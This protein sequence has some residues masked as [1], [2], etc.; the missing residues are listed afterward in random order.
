MKNIKQGLVI[1]ALLSLIPV[2]FI[3]AGVGAKAPTYLNHIK[4]KNL[5]LLKLSTDKYDLLIKKLELHSRFA[6]ISFRIVSVSESELIISVHQGPTIHENTFDHKR[7]RE[8]AHETFDF[9]LGYTQKLH[10]SIKQDIESPPD[11]VTP[12]WINANMKLYNKRIKDIVMDTGIS[13]ANISALL[14]NHKPLSHI[15]KAMFYYYFQSLK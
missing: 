8:I 15:T 6:S 4:M 14:N 13:K 1:L 12:T 7:L 9:V 2:M 5:E 11:I 3:Y 10:V